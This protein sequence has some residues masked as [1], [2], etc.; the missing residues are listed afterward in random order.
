[1][2]FTSLLTVGSVRTRPIVSS[3]SVLFIWHILATLSRLQEVKRS[4]GVV[5]QSKR[6]DGNR[7]ENRAFA[8]TAAPDATPPT[9][10]PEEGSFG[11][12]WNHGVQGD[13][14]VK[15]RTI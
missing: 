12:G 7:P 5:L 15:A 9:L 6:W 10:S 13:C 2:R 3:F 14:V 11:L 1:M 8:R 4:Q